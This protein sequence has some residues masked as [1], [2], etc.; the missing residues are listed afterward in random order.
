MI[1]LDVLDHLGRP[2]GTHPE[3]SVKIRLHLAD[4]LDLELSLGQTHTQ[5]HRQTVVSSRDA[6]ESK[7]VKRSGKNTPNTGI[8]IFN[9]GVSNFLFLVLFQTNYL[10]YQFQTLLQE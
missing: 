8:T 6:I 5:T 2:P 9:L 1:I 10:N 3:S 4:I 7:N